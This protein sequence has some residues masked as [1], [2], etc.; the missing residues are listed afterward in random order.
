MRFDPNHLLALACVDKSG[1]VS[2]AARLLNRSQPAVSMQLKALQEALGER[3]LIRNRYG[4]ELTEVAKSLLPAGQS[5]VRA[6]DFAED[7]H[8]RSVGLEKGLLRLIT[9][10]SVSVYLLPPAFA[11][12][13]E[14]HPGIELELRQGN[15][16]DALTELARGTADIAVIRGPLAD[17]SLRTR[18]SVV[19][20][21]ETVLAVLP[22]HPLAGRERIDMIDLDNLDIVSRGRGTPNRRL[23][24][25][26]ASDAGITLRIR[27]EVTSI[28]GVKEGVLQ[29][30]GGGFLSRLVIAREMQ[31]GR[32]K[33][34]RLN[35]PRFTR[36]IMLIQPQG[37][38]P[39]RTKAFLDAFHETFR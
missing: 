20:T 14:R 23:V 13:H 27:Y 38:L 5:I 8:K 19:L 34:L 32:L 21:D 39:L 25:D 2:G 12:F 16:E 10:T 17:N 4:V 30:F 26:A 36:K 3:L 37:D 11:L 1:S 18:N 28:E 24:E 29:G 31:T 35:D 9:S 15:P 22:D 33:A 6:L 7:L